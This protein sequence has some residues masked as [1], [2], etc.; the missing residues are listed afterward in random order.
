LLY[1]AFGMGVP[2]NHGEKNNAGP[3]WS[4]PGNNP[5]L[6]KNA[7]WVDLRGTKVR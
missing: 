1:R 5:S 2:S 4:K 7:K 6:E 3:A